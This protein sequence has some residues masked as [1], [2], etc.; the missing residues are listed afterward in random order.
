MSY[1]AHEIQGA[2]DSINEL[3]TQNSAAFT[4]GGL[5]PA[6]IKTNLA[7]Q[8]QAVAQKDTAQENAKSALKNTTVQYNTTAQTAVDFLSSTIDLLSG[9]VGKKTPLGKQIL[10]IRKNLNRNK[11]GSGGGDS[12]SSSSGSGSSSSSGGGSSSSS[13]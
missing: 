5:T 12:S 9:A 4:T 7:A 8:G 2:I 3:I 11:R 6:T 10:Q 1:P 13:S